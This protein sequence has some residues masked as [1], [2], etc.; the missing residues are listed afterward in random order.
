MAHLFFAQADL[1]LKDYAAMRDD[2]GSS[3][4]FKK[5]VA[6]ERKRIEMYVERVRDRRQ[7]LIREETR[8]EELRQ[9][10]AEQQ[11]KQKSEL[12]VNE[13]KLRSIEEALQRE[14]EALKRKA[15]QEEQDRLAQ[16]QERKKKWEA[17]N[18]NWQS[19]DRERSLAHV[20]GSKLDSSFL[21]KSF[22]QRNQ[23][24]AELKHSVKPRIDNM[25]VIVPRPQEYIE[26][27]AK[28]RKLKDIIQLSDQSQRSLK[29]RQ[30]KEME[31][32]F[33]TELNLKKKQEDKERLLQRRIERDAQKL[34]F[35]Q[36]RLAVNL[37]K[38]EEDRILKSRRM[39]FEREQR[40][41][42]INRTQRSA[43][44]Q[45]KL[46]LE[47]INDENERYHEMKKNLDKY[48]IVRHQFRQQLMEDIEKIKTGEIDLNE[49][50]EKYQSSLVAETDIT[51]QAPLSKNASESPTSSRRSLVSTLE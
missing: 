46:K 6:R 15:E 1:Q 18:K 9:R 39:Q 14:Q 45:L 25:S 29:A 43:E 49:I 21:T 26:A 22:Y 33:K 10:K 40:L 50:K 16:E 38:L 48:K 11:K 12:Q 42:N 4:G 30:Q 51:I 37:D 7:Q 19:W 41:M 23:S 8:E 13:K 28:V 35:K 20:P 34:G 31:M 2:F 36:Q 44:F 24:L 32:I 47:R 5:F 27:H 17:E 3:D